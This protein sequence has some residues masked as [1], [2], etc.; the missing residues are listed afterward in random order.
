MNIRYVSI[1]T[2]L[3][4]ALLASGPVRAGDDAPLPSANSEMTQEEYA[5]YRART[6]EQL[7]AAQQEARKD[8]AAG[9]QRRA[10]SGYG[11]GY[12]ARQERARGSGDM[13]RAGGRGH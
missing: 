9:T 13:G 8:E 5:A 11:Q 4:F 10:G 3:L 6:G 2:S 7:E 12:H 1:L